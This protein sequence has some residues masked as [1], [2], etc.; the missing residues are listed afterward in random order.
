MEWGDI[1]QTKVN[2][3]VAEIKASARENSETDILAPFTVM[4]SDIAGE[5]CFGESF[6]TGDEEKASHF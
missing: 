4:A 1:L 6:K 2:E 3:T 5:L